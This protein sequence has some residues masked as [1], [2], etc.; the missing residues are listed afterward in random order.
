MA[1]VKFDSQ[2]DFVQHLVESKLSGELHQITTNI[3]YA[4]YQ[5][6]CRILLE[7]ANDDHQ[8]SIGINE[9]MKR[10]DVY[11]KFIDSMGVTAK[12]YVESYV[13]DELA[14]AAYN[15]YDTLLKDEI[16]AYKEEQ[17]LLRIEQEKK[18]AAMEAELNSAN[19]IVMKSPESVKR[20][21]AI[22]KAAGL[23]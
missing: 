4:H 12:S 21:K 8:I 5:E 9:L 3:T 16:L 17:R 1:R 19:T 15:D 13:D 20:A 6:Y 22:L 2:E 11:A 18:R 23:L 14:E 7:A 10:Q